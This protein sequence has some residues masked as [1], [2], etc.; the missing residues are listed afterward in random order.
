MQDGIVEQDAYLG[1]NVREAAT[2]FV[3]YSRLASLLD[4]VHRA[5]TKVA[6]LK[7]ACCIQKQVLGLKISM[8]Y[9][10]LVEILLQ[11]GDQQATQSLGGRHKH[12]TRPEII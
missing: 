3:E 8:T 6:N 5:E 4:L 1:S 10:F 2:S 9:A 7:R 11:G 12:R